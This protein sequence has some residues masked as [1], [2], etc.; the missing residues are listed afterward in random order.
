MARLE[1]MTVGSNL[2]GIAGTEPVNVISVKWYGTAAI[3]ITYRDSKGQLGD[4]VVY[5][6]DEPCIE[7]LTKSLPWSFDADADA[8]RLASEAYRIHLA[9]IFDPYLA[10]HTSSVEPLPH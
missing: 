3:E 9:H 4:R 5:R 10:V 1:E 6:E 7:L 8:M 2:V